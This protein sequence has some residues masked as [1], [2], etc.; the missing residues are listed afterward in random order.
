MYYCIACKQLHGLET[1]DR[2]HVFKTGHHI[3]TNIRYSAGLCQKAVRLVE[4]DS[5]NSEGK[6]D[7]E[8]KHTESRSY[9]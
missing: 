9:A 5:P 6:Q 8:D 3:L 1:Q 7:G 4:P 2:L